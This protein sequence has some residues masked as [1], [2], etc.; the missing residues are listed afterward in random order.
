[1]A[2]GG[3][4]P[5]GIQPQ[6]CSSNQECTTTPHTQAGYHI[7]QKRDNLLVRIENKFCVLQALKADNV[8]FIVAP[9]EADAQMA[10]LAIN[11]MI[12]AVSFRLSSCR[13]L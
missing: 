4:F 10:Y 1:M 9:Y 5:G 8:D 11:G 7:T 12:H 3:I 2:Y 13:P 6:I